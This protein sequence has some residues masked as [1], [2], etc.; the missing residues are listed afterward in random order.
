MINP[1]SRHAHWGGYFFDFL[2]LFSIVPGTGPRSSCFSPP[3]KIMP[4]TGPQQFDLQVFDT[5]QTNDPAAPI[6]GTDIVGTVGVT[7]NWNPQGTDLTAKGVEFDDALWQSP[8]HGP[9][10]VYDNALGGGLQEVGAVAWC[11]VTHTLK[12]IEPDTPNH[13]QRWAITPLVQLTR[14]FVPKDGSPPTATVAF[15]ASDT[16]RGN[17]MPLA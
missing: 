3:L 4:L 11:V 10:T 7:I 14:N 12:K 8:G 6:V 13:R 1:K 5:F 16:V 15:T 2:Q 17:W 9:L